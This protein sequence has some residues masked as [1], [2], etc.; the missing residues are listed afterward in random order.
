[1]E[2][3]DFIERI[4]MYGEFYTEIIMDPE[5]LAFYDE[6]EN[7]NLPIELRESNNSSFNL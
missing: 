4:R 5:F 2:G 3:E 7:A 1:L 6:I